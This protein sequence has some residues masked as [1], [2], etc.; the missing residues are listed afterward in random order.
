MNN[1]QHV[2]EVLACMSV[3]ANTHTTSFT[4]TNTHIVH[5][6]RYN[7]IEMVVYSLLGALYS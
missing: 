4:F 6:L 5:T 7:T 2:C 3:D 1:G